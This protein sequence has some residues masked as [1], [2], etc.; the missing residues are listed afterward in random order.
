MNCR[1][2][3][4][5]IIDTSITTQLYPGMP[6]PSSSSQLDRKSLCAALEVLELPYVAVLVARTVPVMAFA[7]P[8]GK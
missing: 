1:K 6:P 7:A 2:Y 8:A 4:L 3:L 5:L